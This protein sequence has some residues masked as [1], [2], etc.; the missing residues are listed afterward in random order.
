[1]G[2]PL[3]LLYILYYFVS[4]TDLAPELKQLRLEWVLG[5]TTALV[6]ISTFAMTSVMSKVSRQVMLMV[7]FVIWL[8]FVWIPNR[9]LFGPIVVIQDFTR[10]A[11]VYFFVL[12]HLRSTQRLHFL[13]VSL[14]CASVFMVLMGLNQYGAAASTHTATP[15][16]M[17]IEGDF[18][19]PPRQ[20]GLGVLGDP[21]TFGQYLLSL[22]PFLYVSNRP[23]GMSLVGYLVAIP[24]TALFLFAIYHTGSRGALIGLAVLVGLYMRDRFKGVG[25]TVAVL[26][27]L[28]CILVYN[29]VH[30]AR[31]I[32][33]S[34]GV[35]RLLLWSEGIGILKHSPIWGIGM[36]AFS[37][38]VRMNAHN[39]FLLCA[40]ESGLIGFFLWVGLGVVTFRLLSAVINAKPGA[41][42]TPEQIFHSVLARRWAEAVQKSLVVYL[43]TSY[44]LSNTYHLFPYMLAGMAGAIY[45][46]YI[47]GPAPREE[48]SFQGWARQ[49]IFA[50]SVLLVTVWVS[51]HLRLL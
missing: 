39:S 44:F 29:T 12:A 48:V 22:L 1:M 16:V 6:T 18:L 41:S 38:Q 31:D 15:Y 23:R 45:C 10:I 27:G 11:V 42:E 4:P 43:C 46:L 40:C 34:G 26:G 50:C 3:T 36:H 47:D 51:V 21:N 8:A 25:T 49:A 5:V 28:T 9:W 24:T 19:T 2:L 17:V 14:I 30:G 35:D 37:D 32:S 20:R 13:R 33:V 7:A